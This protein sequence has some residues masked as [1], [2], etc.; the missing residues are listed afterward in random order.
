MSARNHT[1]VRAIVENVWELPV[2]R[3]L[4]CLKMQSCVLNVA[5][6]A[7]SSLQRYKQKKME[8]SREKVISFQ[9]GVMVSLEV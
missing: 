6:I 4:S 1:G 7:N 9:Y 2:L 3:H 8:D 5:N